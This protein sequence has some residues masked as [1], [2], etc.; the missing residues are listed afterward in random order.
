MQ[1]QELNIKTHQA[2]AQEANELI[3]QQEQ[4]AEQIK[5]N[6]YIDF[7]FIG[8]QEAKMEKRFI[9]LIEQSNNDLH[10]KFLYKVPEDSSSTLK[11]TSSGADP[12]PRLSYQKEPDSNY[13]K[14]KDNEN[15]PTSNQTVK[16]L[17]LNDDKFQ[18]SQ[19]DLDIIDLVE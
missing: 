17:K 14:N 4:R 3:D 19:D 6:D 15:S 2:K 10:Q 5:S 9:N 11:Q 1:C 13:S 7:K 18:V 12:Q 8:E 16:R